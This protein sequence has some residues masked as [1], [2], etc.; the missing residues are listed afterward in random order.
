MADV[1]KQV[2]QATQLN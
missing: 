1:S 2:L